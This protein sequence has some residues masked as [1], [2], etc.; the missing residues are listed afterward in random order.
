M[1]GRTKSV[2]HQKIE[3]RYS[4]AP[5]VKSQKEVENNKPMVEVN[6]RKYF[7]VKI[8]EHGFRCILTL[9]RGF[10]SFRMTKIRR[11]LKSEGY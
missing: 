1:P 9:S 5:S 10:P 8:L 7:F 6:I 2:D 3:F 11:I 4:F